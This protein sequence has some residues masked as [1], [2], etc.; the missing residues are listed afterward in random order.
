MA[1]Q[2]I[3]ISNPIQIAPMQEAIES[4]SYLVQESCQGNQQA[5]AMLVARYRE[6][7]YRVIYFM[8]HHEEDSW[9]LLQDTFCKAYQGLADL[10][11]PEIV[12]SW[13]TKIAIHLSINFLKK[14]KRFRRHSDEVFETMASSPHDSP[15][16]ILENQE[17]QNLLENAITKLPPKQKSVLILC[18]MEGYSYKEAAQ[19]LQCRLGTVMSRLFYARSFIRDE[20]TQAKES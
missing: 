4:D 13:L 20:M 5:F 10:K 17:T 1:S 6:K 19:I 15:S 2:C 3:S 12:K 16:F 7:L 14:K 18:D 8:V 9:D 11:K